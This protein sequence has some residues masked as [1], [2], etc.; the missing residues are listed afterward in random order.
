MPL[1]KDRITREYEEEDLDD[2]AFVLRNFNRLLITGRLEEMSQEVLSAAIAKE[3]T[4]ID[5][6]TSLEEETLSLH[7][8]CQNL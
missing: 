6:T 5:K 8:L 3:R 2:E 1:W 7:L 4:Y